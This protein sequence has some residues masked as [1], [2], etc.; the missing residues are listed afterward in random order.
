MSQPT[1]ALAPTGVST[2]AT[3]N[4]DS[5]QSLPKS[6]LWQQLLE[7]VPEI[8]N[9][10]HYYVYD[11]QKVSKMV[12]NAAGWGDPAATAAPGGSSTTGGG[13]NGRLGPP[14]NADGSAEESE[15]HYQPAPSV[16]VAINVR[17]AKMAAVPS[18]GERLLLMC[19]D[20]GF[21]VFEVNNSGVFEVCVDLNPPLG[22]VVAICALSKS[23]IVVLAASGLISMYDTVRKQYTTAPPVRLSCGAAIAVDLMRD[24]VVVTSAEFMQLQ[25]LSLPDFAE[26]GTICAE[27]LPIATSQRWLAYCGGSSATAEDTTRFLNKVNESTAESVAKQ[28][29]SGIAAVR[30]GLWGRSPA[31]QP[32][33]VPLGSVVVHDVEAG[34]N[35]AS[36]LAHSHAIQCM[37]FDGS[38]TLL[39]TAST[40]G[41]TVNVFHITTTP[42]AG[43]AKPQQA[44]VTLMHRLCRGMTTGTVV[45]VS[46]SPLNAWIG[47]STAVGTC[48]FYNLPP[49]ARE[50]AGT[51]AE[52]HAASQLMATCR[53]RSAPTSSPVNP[54]IAFLPQTF[55]RSADNVASCDVAIASATGMVSI[56]RCSGGLGA[57]MVYTKYIDGF[58][59]AA[60]QQHV[61][62]ASTSVTPPGASS[63]SSP[64][65]VSFADDE[66][67]W[68]SHIE[69]VSHQSL[70][71]LS[72][73]T[74]PGVPRGGVSTVA[75]AHIE[76]APDG[77]G[78]VRQTDEWDLAEDE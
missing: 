21:A 77:S 34:C 38:G 17:S 55:R 76:S 61:D 1:S 71:P 70:P 3:A 66:D 10:A 53:A 16:Q 49:E 74:I 4:Y 47:F 7:K 25:V 32:A 62:A 69:L 48:H 52:R 5:L 50:I 40:V 2:L 64:P 72:N 65:N 67:A 11:I 9:A 73:F 30:A 28:V 19:I 12:V 29:T 20:N 59:A 75:T 14:T 24:H 33:Q 18:T 63:I 45:D 51:D 42:Y 58:A 37:R 41:T 27:G 57:S 23:K 46:F 26:R 35:I 60:P 56:V 43:G 13:G 6:S 78:E 22:T 15:V 39:A 54:T 31:L 68:R 36:F 44:T 8:R